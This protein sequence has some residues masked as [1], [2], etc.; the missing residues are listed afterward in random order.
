MLSDTHH[1][2]VLACTFLFTH[3][4]PCTW[5]RR[6]GPHTNRERQTKMKTSVPSH[7]LCRRD[8]VSLGLSGK[9]LDT[10]GTQTECELGMELGGKIPI[11]LLV[12]LIAGR[13]SNC[14]KI[15]PIALFSL[16]TVLGLVH[17]LGFLKEEGGLLL[18]TMG[19]VECRWNATLIRWPQYGTHHFQT[20]SCSRLPHGQS[21]CGLGMCSKGSEEHADNLPWLWN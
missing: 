13:P 3:N 6:E 8:P 12:G 14:L 16:L 4:F 11:F 10:A 21:W 15:H 5:D 18:V 17:P 20:H 2:K 9:F 7:F 1:L 19:H